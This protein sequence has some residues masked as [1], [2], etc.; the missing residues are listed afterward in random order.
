MS[1]L[2]LLLLGFVLFSAQ[3]VSA[4][5]REVTGKVTDANGAPLNGASIN[6]KNSRIGTGAGADGTF[7]INVAPNT[8]LVI[9]AVGFEQKE[10]N[11]GSS[12]TIAVKLDADARALREVVVT[13]TGA[14]TSKRKMAI[15]VESV[16]ADK[17]P[18][19]PT[20][21]IDQA[22]VGK[23]PGA[24]ISS[25]NGNPGQGAQILLR[26]INTLRAGTYPMVLLDGIEVKVTDLNSLDLTSVERI[27]VVQG[28]AAATMY[29]AQGANG[30]IQL[31]SKKGRSGRVQ[32][33]ISSSVSANTLLNIGDLHKARF[34][35]LNTDASGNVLG[36]SGNPLVFD[37]DYS[38]YEENVI[39]NS[40]S[41]TNN[42]NK[43]FV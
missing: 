10:V 43:A 30:V 23:I 18:A 26:G 4:Q 20:A 37:N 36:G 29:G 28:A 34:H 11:V 5:T 2:R 7:K 27:E 14:A 41:V 19:A 21:S 16:T 13:G 12:T 32:V 39:W 31:F 9:S 1:K 17:L 35:S 24:Q 25:V 42:N 38:H 33:D 3:I 22:L 8:V 15:A 6:V 40:L